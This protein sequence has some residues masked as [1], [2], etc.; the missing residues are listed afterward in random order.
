[1]E[2]EEPGQPETPV[3]QSPPPARP[4][5]AGGKEPA[6]SPPNARPSRTRRPPGWTTDYDM[7]EMSEVRQPSS[8]MVED[9]GV[10]G[11]LKDD[12]PGS[13]ESRLREATRDAGPFVTC[14]V[15]SS[16]RDEPGTRSTCIGRVLIRMKDLCRDNGLDEN[17]TAELV[18]RL[19]KD[20]CDFPI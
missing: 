13:V 1:M 6:Q 19:A 8:Y 15:G 17:V 18:G 3:P 11:M 20:L 10:G 5:N 14:A 12:I 7:G 9:V 4:G 16:G 2:V